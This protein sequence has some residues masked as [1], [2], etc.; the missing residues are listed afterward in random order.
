[1]AAKN[2]PPIGDMFLGEAPSPVKALKVS[3]G[4]GLD[5]DPTATGVFALFSLDGDRGIRVV[6]LEWQVLE[7]FDENSITSSTS[8]TLTIGDGDDADGFADNTDIAPGTVDSHPAKASLDSTLPYQGG[9]VYEADDT[10]DLTVGGAAPTQSGQLEV[11]LF[12]VEGL[13]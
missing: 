10:I 8:V 2:V 6:D 4:S 3:V 9:T 7:R 1:M 12:Y 5:V 13:D 11:V